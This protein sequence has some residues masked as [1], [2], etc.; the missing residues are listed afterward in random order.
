MDVP[1]QAFGEALLPMLRSLTTSHFVSLDFEMSGVPAQAFK[2]AGDATGRGNRQTVQQRYTD[3]KHAAE[4][5]QI[6]QVGITIVNYDKIRGEYS[7]IGLTKP[8]N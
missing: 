8:T 1:G 2:A 6:L 5:Y 7:P 4:K 3:L